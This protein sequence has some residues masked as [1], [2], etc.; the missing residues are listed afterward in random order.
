MHLFL[1]QLVNG[2]VQGA[3]YV[4]V[5]IGLS[6]VFGVLKV[7]NFAHGE[8]YVVGGFAAYVATTTFGW[9]YWLGVVLAAVAGLVVGGVAERLAIR[10]LRKAPEDSVFL[11]TFGLSL[12]LLYGVK[13]LL[14]G[15]PRPVPT[16]FERNF[17]FGG[18][19][20][21]SQQIFVLVV[22]AVLVCV[23]FLALQRSYLGLMLRAVALDR[24]TG[25]LMGLNVERLYWGAFAVAA[26]LAAVAGA[27]VAPMFSINPFSG[28]DILITAFIVVVI[29]GL[30]SLP[31]AVI[32]GL[33][34]GV[35]EAMAA[36]YL[37]EGSRQWVPY[38]LVVAV[39]LL[40]PQGLFPGRGV[41]RAVAA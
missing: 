36:G 39:L 16:S 26:A 40:R 7:V 8:F 5:A 12:V 27:A 32:V 29:A 35:A 10:P 1:A 22:T 14:G 20:I 21:S 11:S 38:V 24:S 19:V 23:L 31:G 28:Q 2:V 37:P 33:G 18:V 9:P 15:R 17:S 30:G 34:L 4:L 25:A 13:L 6:L 3:V 41:A